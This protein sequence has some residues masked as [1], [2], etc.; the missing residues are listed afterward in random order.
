MDYPSGFGASMKSMIF[1]LFWVS[2]CCWGAASCS[3]ALVP[4]P[5]G[6]VRIALFNGD[7]P[8]AGSAW[9]RTDEVLIDVFYASATQANA[10]YTLGTRVRVYNIANQ[11]FALGMVVS[12]PDSHDD[13]NQRGIFSKNPPSSLEYERRIGWSAQPL[14]GVPDLQDPTIPYVGPLVDAVVVPEPGSLLIWVLFA[15][16]GLLSSIAY[17]RSRREILACGAGCKPP[18][19]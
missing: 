3:A 11:Q 2:A 12:R 10:Q 16:G 13:S 17:R 14:N 1:V 7:M 19:I 15:G 4:L 6:S 18:A 9:V 5:H 8:A